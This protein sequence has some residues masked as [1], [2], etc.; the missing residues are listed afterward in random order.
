[1]KAKQRKGKTA[2]VKQSVKRKAAPKPQARVSAPAAALE[3]FKVK[4]ITFPVVAHIA[5]AGDKI[6]VTVVDQA[7]MDRLVNEHGA[8]S[9]EVQS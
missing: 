2:K 6:P 4:T 8:S 9:V 1:M 5:K 7:H 3:A